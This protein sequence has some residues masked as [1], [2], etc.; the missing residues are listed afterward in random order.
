MLLS[1]ETA[2]QSITRSAQARR[3]SSLRELAMADPD[4]SGER[5]ATSDGQ[6]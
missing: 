1:S 2:Y 5:Q 4:H 3:R 6:H